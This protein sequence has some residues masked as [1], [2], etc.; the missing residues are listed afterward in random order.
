MEHRNAPSPQLSLYI[1]TGLRLQRHVVARRDASSNTP[2]QSPTTEAD[3]VG[4]FAMRLLQR[5]HVE[6]DV[7]HGRPRIVC[8]RMIEL[9]DL[10][11][12]APVLHRRN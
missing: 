10:Q 12:P 5:W 8:T 9:K 11:Q 7:D 4:P 6:H 2:S 1:R 3:F